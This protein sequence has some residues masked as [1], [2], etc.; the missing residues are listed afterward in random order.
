MPSTPPTRLGRCIGTVALAL[1]AVV[2]PLAT[3]SGAADSMVTSS[4]VL[5]PSLVSTDRTAFYSATWVNRS[6]STLANPEVVITLP[7]G[8]AVVSADPPVCTVS[9]RRAPSSSPARGTT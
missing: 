2:G 6:H 8:S 5:A 7:A 1:A 3:A 4:A 9:G